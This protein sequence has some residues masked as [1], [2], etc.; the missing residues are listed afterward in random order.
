MVTDLI[1][2]IPALIIKNACGCVAGCCPFGFILLIMFSL[3]WAVC[4]GALLGLSKLYK[5]SGFL[6]IIPA[7]IG[8]PFAIIGK[9][10][11]SCMPSMGEF[12]QLWE[13]DSICRTFPFSDDFVGFYSRS[14]KE[15]SFEQDGNMLSIDTLN[16]WKLLNEINQI[17]FMRYINVLDLQCV[18]SQPG[19]LR[20]DII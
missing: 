9:T 15:G 20:K 18:R 12:E 14:K 16:R 10:I 4:L 5:V 7:T 2:L 6:R 11:V 3:P 19:P 17:D 8:I 13:K 1:D